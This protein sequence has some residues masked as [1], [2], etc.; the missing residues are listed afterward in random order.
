MPLPAR[1]PPLDNEDWWGKH[2]ITI[3]QNMPKDLPMSY[4]EA[5]VG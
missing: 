4:S 3:G 2:R 1:P 5:Q